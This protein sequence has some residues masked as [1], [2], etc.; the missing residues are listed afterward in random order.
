MRHRVEQ[1]LRSSGSASRLTSAEAAAVPGMVL[2]LS[3]LAGGLVMFGAA[4]G[5]AL[6]YDYGFNVETS[7]DHPVW[8]PSDRD[9]YPGQ[10]AFPA[11]QR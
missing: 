7:G 11:D 3:V 6:V 8:H 4:Y 9:V 1:Q 2:V 5:G 10:E